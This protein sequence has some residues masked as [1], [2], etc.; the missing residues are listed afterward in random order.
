MYCSYSVTIEQIIAI[1]SSYLVELKTSALLLPMAVI[2]QLQGYCIPATR[3]R[4][5]A[6]ALPT[7]CCYDAKV[8]LQQYLRVSIAATWPKYCV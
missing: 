8:L 3:P 4:I 7:H 1:R 5:A 6:A 2:L